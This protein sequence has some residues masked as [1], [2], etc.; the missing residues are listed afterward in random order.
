ML[1][2][3]NRWRFDMSPG[4]TA[5]R[6]R[7]YRHDSQPFH[8]VSVRI[9]AAWAVFMVQDRVPAGLAGATGGPTRAATPGRT[10]RL[11]GTLKHEP[12]GHHVGTSLQE[13]MAA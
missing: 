3:T 4:A 8:T 11:R 9:F 5:K 6:D 12:V 2:V 1:A 13:P 10:V 7:A